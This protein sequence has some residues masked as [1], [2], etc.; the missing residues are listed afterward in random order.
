MNLTVRRLTPVPPYASVLCDDELHL[1]Q[2]IPK[3]MLSVG[4]PYKL[5]PS[6]ST[7]P[8]FAAKM[9]SRFVQL[10]AFFMLVLSVYSLHDGMTTGTILAGYG[11]NLDNGMFYNYN[12]QVAQN[13]VQYQPYYGNGFFG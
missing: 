7:A 13:S 10:L 4:G 5:Q 2:T 8:K 9:A 3:T 11:G 6:F 1:V 12:A